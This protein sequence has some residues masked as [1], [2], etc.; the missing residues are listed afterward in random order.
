MGYQFKAFLWSFAIHALALMITIGTSLSMVDVKKPIVIDFSI[1]EPAGL[2]KEG[3][4]ELTHLPKKGKGAAKKAGPPLEKES[5][6]ERK[7]SIPERHEEAEIKQ[8]TEI[9]H[10]GQTS[11]SISESQVEVPASSSERIIGLSGG[12]NAGV[13]SG[14]QDGLSEGVK[15]G[16]NVAY[17]RGTGDSM[18]KKARYLKE[19][20]VYIRDRIM[21]HLSYPDMARRMGWSGRVMVS[22]VISEDGH[23]NNIKVLES[24]KFGL[25]DKNAVETIKSAS[26][27]PRP[28]VSAEIILPIV[29]RLE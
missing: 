7:E 10:G 8:E 9:I 19:H 25:L 15:T 13:P 3:I 16:T 28:P 4:K 21:K 6:P 5:I 20:F 23:V 12:M 11:P 29:Y 2:M 18:V 24:S 27:F 1:G 17:G 26:P 22:F 14:G